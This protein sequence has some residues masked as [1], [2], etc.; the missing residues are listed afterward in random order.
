MRQTAGMAERAGGRGARAGVNAGPV[1]CDGLGCGWGMPGV[2][3]RM[4]GAVGL[5]LLLAGCAGPPLASP[6]PF[7]TPTQLSCV[8]YAR[9]V[10]GV[11][12]DGD[13][14][15]WWGEAAG[16]YARAQRPRAGAVLV[17][18]PHGGMRLGHL[19][20]VT[21]VQGPRAILVTQANWLPHRIEHGQ[22]VID[23]STGNDWTAVRV[24]YAPA[25]A[26]GRT[27][28]PTYGFILPH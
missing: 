10:S 27:V 1:L 23:V 19:A 12:L 5:C 6:A 11:A 20:V 2:L 25:R 18:A 3:N 9:A 24:W 15:E 17:F 14:W 28:Y 26:M 8:P 7:G 22:E 4:L 21:E 13:A 16:V